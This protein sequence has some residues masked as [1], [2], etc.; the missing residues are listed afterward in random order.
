MRSELVID[1]IVCVGMIAPVIGTT[2]TMTH[3]FRV[4]TV[5]RKFLIKR[6]S[7]ALAREARDELLSALN[8]IS[9]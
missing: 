6:T 8:T 3:G 4:E 1:K 5:T 2:S 7:K 9:L